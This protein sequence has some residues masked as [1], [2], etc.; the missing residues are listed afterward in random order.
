MGYETI[1]FY[2]QPV[3]EKIT[4]GDLLR[5]KDIIND[6]GE[7]RIVNIYSDNGYSLEW[8]YYASKNCDADFY[9]DFSYK[10]HTEAESA[11][12]KAIEYV[13]GQ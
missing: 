12:R 10:N 2:K 5:C 13:L 11:L 4:Y 3:Y 8:S 1:G 9:C 6:G 7:W